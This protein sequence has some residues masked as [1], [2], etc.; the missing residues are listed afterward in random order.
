[1][2]HCFKANDNIVACALTTFHYGFFAKRL[3]N[4]VILDFREEFKFNPDLY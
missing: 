4:Q 1:M 2:M 3:L